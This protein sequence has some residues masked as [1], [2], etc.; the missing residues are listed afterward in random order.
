M[1]LLGHLPV[2]LETLTPSVSKWLSMFLTLARWRHANHWPSSCKYDSQN[3]KQ[4]L[5]QN[6]PWSC[7]VKRLLDFNLKFLARQINQTITLGQKNLGDRTIDL[8]RRKY[9]YTSESKYNIFWCIENPMSIANYKKTLR[10]WIKSYYV[11]AQRLKWRCYEEAS[12]HD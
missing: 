12:L 11:Y 8:K 7:S 6:T 9:N 4:Q 10:F 3:E 2:T 1:L 5:L